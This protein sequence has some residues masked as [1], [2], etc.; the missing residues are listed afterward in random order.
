MKIDFNMQIFWG[1]LVKQFVDSLE[2]FSLYFLKDKKST[3]AKNSVRVEEVK[4]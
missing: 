2:Q 4:L 1:N 3:S